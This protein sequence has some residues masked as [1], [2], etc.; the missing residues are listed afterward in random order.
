MTSNPERTGS[1]AVETSSSEPTG[2]DLRS[3]PPQARTVW[4]LSNGLVGLGALAATAL[5]YGVGA[6]QTVG[7]AWAVA[8]A[9]G[10]LVVFLLE[11]L[12]FIPRRFKYS[13]FALDRDQLFSIRGSF[14]IRKRLQPWRHVLF[15]EAQQGPFLRVFGLYRV[16]IGTIADAHFEGPFTHAVVQELLYAAKRKG[17]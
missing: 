17:V 7:A 13:K 8:V 9:S 15:V 5:L 12:I 16:R 14:W 3:L 4:Q 2:A 6:F 11:A 1:H 10:V